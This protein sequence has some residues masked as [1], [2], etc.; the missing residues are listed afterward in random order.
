[1]EKMSGPIYFWI[2][3]FFFLTKRHQSLS[4]A[5]HQNHIF[6]NANQTEMTLANLKQIAPFCFFFSWRFQLKFLLEFI[7]ITRENKMKN[8]TS[9][10]ISKRTFVGHVL[11]FWIQFCVINIAP[12]V[13]NHSYSSFSDAEDA[14]LGIRH[15]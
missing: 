5:I 6:S 3:W 2:N 1:M 8:C 7:Q 13:W 10:E 9:E 12:N 15:F 14:E 11:A 4:L